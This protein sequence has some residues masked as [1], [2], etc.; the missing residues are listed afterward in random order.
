MDFEQYED[1]EPS[2][3]SPKKQRSGRTRHPHYRSVRRRSNGKWVCEVREPH[4]RSRIWLGTFPT[5]EM[6]AV[7]HDVAILTLHGDG[8]SHL[9]FPELAHFLPRAASCSTTDI[10]RAAQQAAR[11][12]TPPAAEASNLFETMEG[13]INVESRSGSGSGSGGGYLDEEAVFNL[14]ALIDG[15][16]EG[17]L[18]TPPALKNGFNWNDCNADHDAH[19]VNL[20]NF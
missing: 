9:N 13:N 5:P 3:S 14:P 6:A 8:A 10:Q 15:M 19:D 20:W 11:D 18:L 1:F 4:A 7:A 12:F 17:M 2:S 16:A